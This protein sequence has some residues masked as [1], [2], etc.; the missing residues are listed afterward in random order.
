VAY[1]EQFD[2]ITSTAR[3]VRRL[4]ERLDGEFRAV[5]AE[6]QRVAAASTLPSPRRCS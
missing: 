4:A 1:A 3:Q 5:V 6:I 2:S